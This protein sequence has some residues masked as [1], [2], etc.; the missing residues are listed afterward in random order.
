M[1]AQRERQAR[2]SLVSLILL[3]CVAPPPAEA[4]NAA[5]KTPLSFGA[6]SGPATRSKLV[7]LPRVLREDDGELELSSSSR[8][9]ADSASASTAQQL[10]DVLRRS[11][12][13]ELTVVP[14]PAKPGDIELVLA[15][16]EQSFGDEG[17]QLD[18]SDRATLRAATPAGLFYASVTLRELL[19]PE[20]EAGSVQSGVSWKVPRVHIEDAPRY[21]W[22][23]FSLD[24]ARHFFPV[25]DVKRWIDLAAYHKLN[26]FHLHLTDDQGWRIE[27]K[28]WPK[29]SSVGGASQV[30]GGSG[31]FY[32]QEQFRELVSYADARHITLIPEIDMPGHVG[33]ALAAYGELNRDGAPK[34]PYT[35]TDVGFSSLVFDDPD[36]T[37]FVD[38]IVREVSSLTTGPY[39]HVGGDEAKATNQLDY[40]AFLKQVGGVLRR[41]GKSPVAWCEAGEAGLPPGTVLQDWHIGCTGS[42][43]GVQNGMRVVASPAKQAYLDMKYDQSSP[44]GTSW[45]GFVELQQAY[46]WEPSVPGVPAEAIIGIESALWSEHVADRAAADYL[47]FPRLAGHAELAWSGKRYNFAE[48]RVRLAHHGK[49]LAALG[50]GFYRS[51]QVV[52]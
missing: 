8:I 41:Y 3:G 33:A 7:P 29:L 22:R 31:G 28:S 15:A 45:A 24:V 49:R 2:W 19:P 27:I 43:T 20:V 35:G 23:G 44:H 39:L 42:A 40:K 12:G 34:P 52:W 36:T 48:Y 38:D 37:R 4:P 17:Y 16:G 21:G 25:Q 6:P 14:P 5:S 47:I 11:T 26:R 13:F 18:V 32:T 51:P 46:E 9:V 50:V 10:A 30:G 1:A